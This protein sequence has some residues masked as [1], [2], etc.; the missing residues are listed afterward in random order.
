VRQPIYQRSVARW[1]HYENS[2]GSLFDRL[3]DGSLVAV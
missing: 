1:R 3:R 2:L